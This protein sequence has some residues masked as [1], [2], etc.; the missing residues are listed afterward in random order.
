MTGR[1]VTIPLRGALR[2]VVYVTRG[3]DPDAL[4]WWF[5]DVSVREAVTE[6]ECAAIE[7]ICLTDL[8]ERRIEWRTKSLLRRITPYYR[9]RKVS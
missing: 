4:S 3:D 5:A 9:R 6:A 1:V 7:A 8:H 2:E